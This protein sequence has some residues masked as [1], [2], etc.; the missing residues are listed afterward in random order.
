MSSTVFSLSLSIILFVP[1]T[2]GEVG[3]PL[4]VLLVE[5]SIKK[6]AVHFATSVAQSTL[7]HTDESTDVFICKM[8]MWRRIQSFTLSSDPPRYTRS[9]YQGTLSRAGLYFMSTFLP[10][11]LRPQRRLQCRPFLS[12]TY[13]VSYKLIFQ[14]LRSLRYLHPF[15]SKM[16]CARVIS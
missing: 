8:C 4:V 16:Y 15:F 7:L 2:F 12:A 11:C 6:E 13:P 10:Q 5:V 3:D 9:L 14:Y 1:I